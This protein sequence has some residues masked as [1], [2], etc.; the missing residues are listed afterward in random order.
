MLFRR[1]VGR[2]CGIGAR[3]GK[4]VSNEEGWEFTHRFSK[5]ITRFLQKN[6][7]MSDLLK[8]T[9]DSLIFGERPEPIAHCCLFLVNDMSNSLTSL[10]FDERPERFGLAHIAHQK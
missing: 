6:E 8:K 3:V 7:Q 5:Q 2:G 9:S 4:G 10:I 1:Q